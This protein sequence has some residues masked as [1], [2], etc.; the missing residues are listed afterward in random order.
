MLL[1]NAGSY[2]SHIASVILSKNFDGGLIPDGGSVFF[3]LG[4]AYTRSSVC[5]VPEAITTRLASQTTPR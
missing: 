2:E 1:T 5:C 3:S 4:Y